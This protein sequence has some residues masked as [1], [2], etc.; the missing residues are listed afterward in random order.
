MARS[1]ACA[2]HTMIS[3][4]S[5]SAPMRRFRPTKPGNG[6][7]SASACGSRGSRDSHPRVSLTKSASSWCAGRC[8]SR[9]ASWSMM[10]TR[11]C[12]PKTRPGTSCTR[13]SHELQH[14][15]SRRDCSRSSRRLGCGSRT[16][17]ADR[18]R[19]RPCSRTTTCCSPPTGTG[20]APHNRMIWELL[21]RG[22]RGRIAS[23]AST[24][25]RIDQAYRGMHERL[26]RLYPS[27]RHIAVVT[28]EKM[29]RLQALLRSGE[30]EERADFALD[31]SRARV[32]SVRQPG[33]GRCAPPA[34]RESRVHAPGRHGRIA[35]TARVPLRPRKRHAQHP[36][37]TLLSPRP[38]AVETADDST[39][40]HC[41]HDDR[42]TRSRTLGSGGN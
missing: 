40:Q 24:R 2:A 7:R 31:P 12:A 25:Q 4:C 33:D 36:L 34:R 41:S 20:E 16:R 11:C 42:H 10:A 37:R 19:L 17:R 1:S 26:M 32:F 27:Y 22:H 14:R 38:H 30:L 18:T 5:A 13:P 35:R 28:G 6:F 21:R 3:W 39:A 9:R 23:F 29:P 8:R 15:H